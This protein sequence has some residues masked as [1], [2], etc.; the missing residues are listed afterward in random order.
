MTEMWLVRHGQTDWN[1]QE[2]IQGSIDCPLNEQ[3][4][5]QANALAQTLNGQTLYCN[6]FKPCQTGASHRHDTCRACPFACAG[7]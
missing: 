3:G 4:I 6:L 1:V 7:G 5:A 2:R